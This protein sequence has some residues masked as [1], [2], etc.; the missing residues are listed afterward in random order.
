[1][2]LKV[3]FMGTPGFAVGALEAVH[4]VHQVVGVYTQ[5]DKPVGRGL[6]VQSSAV[7]NKA[8]ELGL[9]IFQPEKLSQEGEF[10][11][12]QTLA[13]DVIVIVAYGQILKRN[14]LDLPRLGC[15]NI[16]SSLL[17]RWR[18]A[19]PIHWALLG[20]DEVTGVSTMHLVPKLDAGDVLLQAKT[21]VK[22]DDTLS[23]L[24]D[25][26]ASMGAE[27]II[28]TLEGLQAGTLMGQVQDESLVTYAQKLA[29]EME[30]L[31]PSE[32]AFLLDRKVRALNPWPGTS[33][34]LA[35][36]ERLKIKR[37][38]LRRD[39]QGNAGKIF[40]KAGMALL[41]TPDGALELLS[42][43]WDGK[44]EVDAAGFLNGL[45]GRGQSLPLELS[46]ST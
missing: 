34:I 5:P 25:R 15:I 14:I 46:S 1:M 22:E 26:L 9:P 31:K 7:K 19:A 3:V 11:R 8:V 2:T 38:K 32:S 40:E 43:Q 21:P 20:G 12:L 4:K 39:I 27:L 36:G 30:A 42:V 33:V 29:K 44:K 10:E 45:R 23:T 35:T 18:G 17:P 6:E 41:G 28:P 37:A 16:H 24:H 13:P